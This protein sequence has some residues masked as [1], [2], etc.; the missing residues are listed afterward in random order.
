MVG[1]IEAPRKYQFSRGFVFGYWHTVA[2]FL[3]IFCS[4]T[5]TD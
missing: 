1:G 2:I 4:S 3:S 5:F